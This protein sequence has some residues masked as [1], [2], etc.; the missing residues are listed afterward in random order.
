MKPCGSNGQLSCGSPHLV[1]L[2][3]F[4]AL[5][6]LKSAVNNLPYMT[7]VVLGLFGQCNAQTS[8]VTHLCGGVDR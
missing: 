4:G 8:K 5:T 2:G 3:I 1:V 6:K 7:Q